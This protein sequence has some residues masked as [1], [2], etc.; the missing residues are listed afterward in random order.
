M[1]QNT[2]DLIPTTS[3]SKVTPALSQPHPSQKTNK[4]TKCRRLHHLHTLLQ[5]YF[6]FYLYVNTD[7]SPTLFFVDVFYFT[8]FTA[9]HLLLPEARTTLPHRTAYTERCSRQ[10]L[11]R[12]FAD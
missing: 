4:E 11:S 1:H 10:S 8:C 7:I 5:N 6:I 2:P 9:H 12:L 3:P